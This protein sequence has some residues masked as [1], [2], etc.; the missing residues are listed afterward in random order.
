MGSNRPPSSEKKRTDTMH[1]SKTFKKPL[2]T[3]KPCKTYCLLLIL[4]QWNFERIFGA[5]E[6]SVIAHRSIWQQQMPSQLAQTSN[7]E[8]FAIE[9]QGGTV[10]IF[11]SPTIF[12]RATIKAGLHNCE[13]NNFQTYCGV[14]D[15]SEFSRVSTSMLVSFLVTEEAR[16]P[17]EKHTNN[18]T[19]VS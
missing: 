11:T 9:Y 13:Q 18:F 16:N 19:S 4:Q 10:A 1:S 3:C 8:I 14:V 7:N 6:I 12:I 15:S 5:A 17:S 2:K